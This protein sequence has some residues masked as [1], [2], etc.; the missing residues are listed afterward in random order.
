VP[1][2]L[3]SR[4]N[5]NREDFIKD[6]ELYGQLETLDRWSDRLGGYHDIIGLGNFLVKQ[7]KSENFGMRPALGNSYGGN[8]AENLLDAV[9]RRFH[10]ME[11]KEQSLLE[12]I[13]QLETQLDYYKSQ[14]DRHVEPKIRQVMDLCK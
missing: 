4:L 7:G 8:L 14:N 12:K 10:A 1:K 13:R 5:G 9:L 6:V 3:A 11:T 2:S